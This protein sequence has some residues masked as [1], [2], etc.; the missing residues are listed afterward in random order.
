MCLLELSY[1]DVHQIGE[2]LQQYDV[3]VTCGLR[4]AYLCCL[5]NPL[6]MNQLLN[7]DAS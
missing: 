7:L 2:G 3:R 5:I 4:C 6:E 1:N